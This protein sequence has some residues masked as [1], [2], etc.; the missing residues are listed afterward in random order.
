MVC[1]SKECWCLYFVLVNS[2]C[3]LGLKVC[4]SKQFWC[5]C[6]VLVM[7]LDVDDFLKKSVLVLIIC[8]SKESWC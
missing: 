4:F 5:W 8:F 1:V 2:Q 6:F 7:C 3:V